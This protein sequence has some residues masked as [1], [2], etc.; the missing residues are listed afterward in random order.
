MFCE[1]HIENDGDF[2]I[3][4]T[5]ITGS[6][7]T[8]IRLT[9]FNMSSFSVVVPDEYLPDFI[10]GLLISYLGLKEPKAKEKYDSVDF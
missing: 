4:R 8:K 7:V 2:E 9:D 10:Y 5:H 3:I 1:F 6:Q